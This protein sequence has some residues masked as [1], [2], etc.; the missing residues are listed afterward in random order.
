[1]TQLTNILPHIV[2]TGDP[3]QA[4]HRAQFTTP[5][6]DLTGFGLKLTKSASLH[7]LFVLFLSVNPIKIGSS[8]KSSI[9]SIYRR[10]FSALFHSRK[11]FA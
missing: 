3:K 5:R 1:M 6:G 7:M 10:K 11:Q 2:T 9:Y 4:I 8:Y